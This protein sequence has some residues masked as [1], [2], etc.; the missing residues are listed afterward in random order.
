ME[1]GEQIH[2][3]QNQS[4]PRRLI[5]AVVFLHISAGLGLLAAVAFVLIS[6]LWGSF[7]SALASFALSE[8]KSTPA[9]LP[10]FAGY[11]II[12]VIVVTGAVAYAVAAEVVVWGLNRRKYWAWVMGIVVAGLQILTGWHYV[13]QV[14]LAGFILWGLLDGETVA[15]FRTAQEGRICR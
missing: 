13:I 5:L 1:R 15:A 9:V 6:L 8:G 14:V 7:N 4:K 2:A 10:T 12:A 11:G 3:D